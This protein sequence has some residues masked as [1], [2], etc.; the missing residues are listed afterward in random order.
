MSYRGG[1]PYE[2]TGHFWVRTWPGGSRC[3]SLTTRGSG[4]RSRRKRIS[5]P[6]VPSPRRG[7]TGIVRGALEFFAELIE[8][9][10]DDIADPVDAQHP[11]EC[12]LDFRIREQVRLHLVPGHHVAGGRL[13]A[14]VL[15][16][17]RHEPARVVGL[18]CHDLSLIYIGAYDPARF[19]SHH[20]VSR[21]RRHADAATGTLFLTRRD[22][23]W[24]CH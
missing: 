22:D 20:G 2:R 6:T 18:R 4:S 10:N 14:P 23:R 16:A 19:R 5:A 1:L 21:V 13:P 24:W 11:L 12:S 8:G 9:V 17:D 3:G 15:E 7:A